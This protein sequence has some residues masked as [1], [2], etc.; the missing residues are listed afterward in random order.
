MI[1]AFEDEARLGLLSFLPLPLG[2]GVVSLEPLP[3]L[4]PYGVGDRAPLL[5]SERVLSDPDRV[6]FCSESPTVDELALLLPADL[7]LLLDLLMMFQ[8]GEFEL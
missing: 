8:F 1:L 5:P 7:P 2:V 3:L 6:R 4:L